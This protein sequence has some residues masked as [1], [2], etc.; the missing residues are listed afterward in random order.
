MV[1]GPQGEEGPPHPGA[2][3][4]VVLQNTM[5]VS[6]YWRGDSEGGE[7]EEEVSKHLRTLGRVCAEGERN[8][9]T[10]ISLESRNLRA[11]ALD[12]EPIYI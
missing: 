7:R 1:W 10:S 5:I 4:L 12:P 6:L 3:G 11:P 8:G 2:F 9:W